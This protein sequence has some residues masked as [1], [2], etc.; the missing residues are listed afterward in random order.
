MPPSA[1][2]YSTLSGETLSACN[3]NFFKS[4]PNWCFK[5]FSPTGSLNCVCLRLMGKCRKSKIVEEEAAKMVDWSKMGA[6]VDRFFFF[7]E[8][9]LN[10]RHLNFHCPSYTQITPTGKPL[11]FKGWSRMLSVIYTDTDTDWSWRRVVYRCT[12]KNTVPVEAVEMK[13]TQT[14][15]P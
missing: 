5:P 8:M 10:K 13:K 4:V 7:W 14:S 15:C 9:M 11:V 2:R 6:S 1:P 3:F 12:V